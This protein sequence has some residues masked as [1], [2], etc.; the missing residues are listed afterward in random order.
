MKPKSLPKEKQIAL[1]LIDE[2][3]SELKKLHPDSPPHKHV[4]ITAADVLRY[5]NDH[6][7]SA[8]HYFIRM[9]AGEQCPNNGI[10]PAVWRER[11]IYK[12]ALVKHGKPANM[13][14]FTSLAEA[15]A[16]FVKLRFLSD[17]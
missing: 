11:A 3:F 4:T 17:R 5:F 9:G 12:V 1:L 10:A 16:K 13:E 2:L 8:A 14:S 15:L 7:A 6:P